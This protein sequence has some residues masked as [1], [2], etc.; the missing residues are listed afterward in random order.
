MGTAVTKAA[1]AAAGAAYAAGAVAGPAAGVSV[2]IIVTCPADT[3][4]APGSPL[5]VTLPSASGGEMDILVLSTCTTAAGS[6]SHFFAHPKPAMHAHITNA[7]M[8]KI[9]LPLLLLV[10]S[11][12]LIEWSIC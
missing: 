2:I 10:I 7:M 9:N 11:A 12:S 5:I 6:N 1:G 8:Q 4:T 3:D